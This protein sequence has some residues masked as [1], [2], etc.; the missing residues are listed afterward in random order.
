MDEPRSTEDWLTLIRDGADDL[1]LVNTLL[2]SLE[3]IV[4]NRFQAYNT[5]QLL[6]LLTAV[7][8]DQVKKAHGLT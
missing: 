1:T 7:R 2:L 4:L 8:L 3:P 5:M 6:N